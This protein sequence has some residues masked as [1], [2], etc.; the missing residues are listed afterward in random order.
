MQMG[1]C[2][3]VLLLISLGLSC[4]AL[5]AWAVDTTVTT[6]TVDDSNDGASASETWEPAPHDTGSATATDN[7]KVFDAAG[8]CEVQFQLL[9]GN[10]W[11]DLRFIA[12]YDKNAGRFASAAGPSG[13]QSSGVF[14]SLAA[15]NHS[16]VLQIRLTNHETY[17]V[18]AGPRNLA[19]CTYEYRTAAPTTE[20]FILQVQ[21]ADTIIPIAPPNGPPEIAIAISCN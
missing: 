16:G 8:S 14:E 13:C 9:P 2:T 6:T 4:S 19:T 17:A 18:V 11:V 12:A 3:H 15:E 20:D 10:D 21:G 5:E 7:E 1:I